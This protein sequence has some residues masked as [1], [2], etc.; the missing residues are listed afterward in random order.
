MSEQIQQT[1]LP[2]KTGSKRIL[3]VQLIFIALVVIFF[4]FSQSTTAAL[5]A[6]YGGAMAL[7]NLWISERRLRTA[8]SIAKIAP[9][10]EAM[11]LY[12]GA[13]QRFIFSALFFVAGM[14]WLKL[15][16]IPLLIAFSMAQV[17]YLFKGDTQ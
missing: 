12:F 11:I 5:A 10:K 15:P 3:T 8:A 9:Q 4:Y 13:I 2:L 7:S 17:A 6:F 16:P 1:A 14:L